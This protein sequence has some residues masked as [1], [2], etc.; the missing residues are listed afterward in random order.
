MKD[1]WYLKWINLRQLFLALDLNKNIIR[2]K[3]IIENYK[4]KQV[5][6]NFLKIYS[7]K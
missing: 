4:G 7:I 2:N 3:K 1:I 5:C 6:T